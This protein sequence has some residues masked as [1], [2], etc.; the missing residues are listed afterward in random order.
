MKLFINAHFG[1]MAGPAGTGPRGARC[2][3][4]VH[5]G[6]VT[7]DSRWGRCRE[8]TRLNEQIGP[9]VPCDASACVFFKRTPSTH[10]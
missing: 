9:A 3:Q 8:Y 5:F 2:G 10:S 1:G 6:F 4:C 7:N